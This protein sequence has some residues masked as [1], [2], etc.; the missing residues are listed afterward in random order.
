MSLRFTRLSRCVLT[1][2]RTVVQIVTP[3]QVPEHARA[4]SYAG[5]RI[6][7]AARNRQPRREGKKLSGAGTVKCICVRIFWS[8]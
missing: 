6:S 7:F 1:G 3:P 4:I 8:A 5:K 2:S